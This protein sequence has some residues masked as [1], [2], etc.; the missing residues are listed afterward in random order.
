MGFLEPGGTAADWPDTALAE[1]YARG[2]RPARM[3]RSGRWKL[4]VY[5]GYEYPQLFDME[6]D[7]GEECDLGRDPACAAARRDLM[8]RVLD[9]W[10]G[11]WIERCERQLADEWKLTRQWAAEKKTGESER[12]T[13]R[14][15]INVRVPG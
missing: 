14:E 2:Q 5:H 1:T 12:W 9:G 15:G 13:M 11:Q 3:I 6:A 7:P 8:A 4:N 10:S